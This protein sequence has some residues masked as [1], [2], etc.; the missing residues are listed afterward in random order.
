MGRCAMRASLWWP[1]MRMS[2]QQQAEPLALHSARP[3]AGDMRLAPCFGK[4]QTDS[5]AM[6]E[7]ERTSCKTA[8]QQ[9]FSRLLLTRARDFL[10]GKRPRTRAGRCGASQCHASA[11]PASWV[12]VEASFRRE[13]LSFAHAMT[14][15]AA[16]SLSARGP[17]LSVQ[18]TY[19]TQQSSPPPATTRFA[20]EDRCLSA[21]T[22]VG[23][24]RHGAANLQNDSPAASAAVR[25][26]A[27]SRSTAEGPRVHDDVHT[28]PR[29]LD[30]A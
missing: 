28:T 3:D 22:A 24:R 12:A 6:G 5:L 21:T 26:P 8:A 19:P 2:Y 16:A 29:C 7:P 30:E 25:I 17:S 1:R 11:S 18:A 9:Y 13:A 14:L 20:P 27:P 4:E 10:L 23:P 15:R